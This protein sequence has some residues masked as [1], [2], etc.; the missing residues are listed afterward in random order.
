MKKTLSLITPLYRTKRRFL[1]ELIDGLKAQANDIELVLIN[2]SPTDHVLQFSIDE[3]LATYKFIRYYPNPS[4]LGLFLAYRNGFMHATGQ[5]CCILDHDDIINVSAICPYLRSHPEADMVYTNEYK[6]Y[7]GHPEEKIIFEKPEFDVLSTISYF[8]THHI[9]IWHTDVLQRALRKRT[10]LQTYHFAFDIYALFMYMR[11]YSGTMNVLHYSEPV[12]GWRIHE[13]STAANLNQKP[14]GFLERLK[15]IEEQLRYFGEDPIVWIHPKVGYIG[16]FKTL[17]VSDKTGMPM[18]LADCEA[19]FL[20]GCDGEG[21]YELKPIGCNAA[22]LGQQVPFWY[23]VLS[24]TPLNYLHHF[25]A[26]AFF[27]PVYSLQETLDPC[28][29]CHAMTD[30]PFISQSAKITQKTQG[31]LLRRKGIDSSPSALLMKSLEN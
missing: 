28:G 18:A 21:D 27:L 16:E 6:Y 7:D 19:W 12:Y 26:D 4:N 11:E 10:D 24:H 8:Y 25:N 5:Y 15:L 1:M 20:A 2:D 3:L 29:M 17:S 30:V 22:V 31:L 13:N 23:K 9:T 14:I